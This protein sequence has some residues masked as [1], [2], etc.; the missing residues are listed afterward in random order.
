MRTWIK[1]RLCALYAASA[2]SSLALQVEAA[3]GLT[4]PILSIGSNNGSAA[5]TVLSTW[6]ESQYTNDFT[7]RYAPRNSSY[8][9][10]PAVVAG[11]TGWSWSQSSPTQ[12]VSTPSGIV[13]PA[14]N[15]SLY[16]LRTTNLLVISGNTVTAPYYY[17]AGKTSGQSLVFNLIS[18]NQQGK[19]DTDLGNLSGAYIGSGGSPA[20]RNDN[21]A[22]RIAVE[23]LDW[24]RWYPNY[25]MSGPGWNVGQ[26]EP[27]G[28]NFQV[29]LNS[30]QRASDH[31]GLAHEWNDTPLKAF[32]AIYDSVVLTNMNTEFGFNVRDFITTNIFFFEGDFFENNVPLASAIGSNLSG[33]FDVLPEVARVLNRPDY[34]VWMD[35]YLAATVTDN[36]NRDGQLEQ[37]LGYSIG[38]LNA[39]V[40]AAQNTEYYFLTRPATNAQFLAISNR[41]VVYATSLQY[42][43]SE[44]SSIALPNG[45]LPSFGDTPFDTYFSTRSS[46]NSYVL[47]NYG[48]V[49]MGAG[50]TSGTAVQVNQQYAGNANHMRSDTTAYALWAFGNEYLGN[51]RYYNG[52]IGRSWGEQLLEKNAVVINRTDLTPFPNA[53]TYGNA[54]LSLYEPGNNGLAMTEIDGYRDYSGEASRFQRLL[55]FNSVDITK[56]YLVDVFRVT[57]GTNHDYTFHGAILWN[58]NS[59][60]SFPLVTNNN[61]YPMLEGSETWSLA[62]DTPYYGFFR[63]ISSNTAP[64]NFYLTYTDTNRA[65][66]RDTRL[67]MTADPNVYNVYLGTTPVPARDNTVPT[68]FFN[69]MNISR[70]SAIIRHHVTSG[71]LSD[72]YV[73]VIEPFNVGVSNIVSVQR[74]P[75]SGS[76]LESCGLQIT[77]K[78]GRVDTYIV[79]LHNTKVAGASAG[80][81]T[82]STADGQ[83]SL[84]GRVGLE[85]DRTNADSRVVTMNAT[86]FKYPGREWTT[87]STY[88]SGL[89]AGAT[90]KFDGAAYDAFTTATPLPT[91]TALRNKYLSF[92]HGTLSGSSTTNISELFKIDQV[93]YTNGLYSICFTNDHFLE[94]TNGLTSGEQ[95]APMRTFTTSN[96]FEIAESAYAQQISAIANQ[97]IPPGGNSGPLS[98][99]FGNLGNTTGAALQITA[100]SSN[101]IVV[102]NANLVLGGSGT[103]RTVT[104]TPASGQTGTSLITVSVTDGTWTNSRIFNVSVGNFAVLTSPSVQSALTGTSVNYT[105]V[106]IATNGTGTI[107]FG[108]S[109]LPVGVNASFTPTT[110]TGAGT[111]VLSLMIS[112]SVSPGTYP[113]IISATDGLQQF[114]SNTVTLIINAITSAPGWCTWTGGSSA[115]NYWNDSTNWSTA[116]VP[117]NSLAF[118]GIFRPNNTNNTTAGITYSNLVFNPGAAAFMLNGNPLLL[119]SGITNN[120]S[121]PQTIALG[122]IFSNN[123]I[124]NGASNA[125]NISGGLTN[126][127]GTAGATSIIL[128]GTGTLKNLF[129]STVNPGGTNLLLLNSG[130]ANWTLT[131][132]NTSTSMTVP[133]IF[134]VNSGTFNFG[135]ENNAPVLT[136]TTVNGITQDH[137]AGTVSGG[138]GIFNMVNGSLTTSARFN[139]AVALNST[140]MVNQT[141]GTLTIG[142]QFQGANGSNLGEVSLVTVSGG[143]MNIGTALSPTSPFYVASRGTGTLTITNTGLVSCGKLDISRNADG[144]SVSSVGIVNLDGGTLSVSS[145]TNV[146]ANQQ[147]GGS[148]SATF[149]FN[150]GTLVAK[151]GAA[152]IFFQGSTAVPVTPIKTFVRAGGAIIDDGGNTI[153]I[154]EPLQHDPALG[155]APDGGL[156]KLDSGTLTLTA[157]NSYTGDTTIT[158]GTLALAANGSISNSAN[159]TLAASTTLDV[160]S[161]SDGRLTLAAGQTLSGLGLLKGDATISGTISPGGSNVGVITNNGSMTFGS[162]GV[163]AVDMNDAVGFPDTNWD[164]LVITNG[165]NVQSSS[166]NPFTVKLRSID[167]NLNDNFPGTA[168][169]GNASSQS[170]MI[171]TVDGGITNFAAN[172]FTVDNGGFQNDLAGGYFTVQTNANAIWLAFVPN[173]PPSANDAYFYLPANG[174]LQIPLSTLAAQWSDPDGDPVQLVGVTNSSAMGTNNVSSDGSF[175]YY[176]NSLNLADAITYT[177]ADIRTNPP[178]VYRP[179][180]TQLTAVGVIHILPPPAIAQ[181]VLAGNNLIFSGTG[182]MAGSNYYVLTSSNLILPI[183]QWQPLATNQFDPNGVFH[184]TNEAGAGPQGYYLL[185]LP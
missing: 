76:S 82:V 97:A 77:F 86:D 19:R 104:V 115:G 80:A 136:S 156:T 29:P 4:H 111:N 182:G 33:P 85:I 122:I 22:R 59:L 90:R 175:I 95:I 139:T 144:N 92:T 149:N 150:G 57:G 108:L 23:L 30:V 135:D 3:D 131:D 83:Y 133:W 9:F 43:Q 70:P 177:I 138:A 142:N 88:Y 170:W 166:A 184:F 124:F 47:G 169:F 7:P 107:T 101:P 38:Y 84:A 185:K 1:T 58:Q 181:I 162:N 171:A 78:D 69:Y 155:S 24:G 79:N 154:A 31:N 39:N 173:N 103:N 151:S 75:M 81:A 56:P 26:F 66:A 174:Q 21:Y 163:Y 87:P 146:S 46:G 36:I 27:G 105:N 158:D 62:T 123:L 5:N 116:P 128:A 152:S 134:A 11:D 119:A 41:S 50:T 6:T 49:S 28:T 73:S 44:L 25:I 37:G 94:I 60:C 52:A 178:A 99:N 32:D 164:L 143:V 145:V 91:G 100:V 18:Y 14:T 17:P 55:L 132:N 15:T 114:A 167:L 137:Q 35:Q 67:W 61:P 160:S 51:V 65:T 8:G 34:I 176:T 106:I 141:G 102:P 93:V 120:S 126:T 110:T 118:G 179:G 20:T 172:K 63:G 42:G 165:L 40:T 113:L 130:S 68:N 64:G 71:T 48:H 74:L 159:I 140:G 10:V 2:L 147:T 153:T 12:I 16:P 72:L 161:R 125:L 109:G 117:G 98:F 54:N 112:N 127:F 148:P 53:T 121:V 157:T 96:A 45:E 89:I 180:D 168:D 129:K 183:N 13:F